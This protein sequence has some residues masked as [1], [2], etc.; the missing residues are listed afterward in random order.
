MRKLV[1]LKLCVVSVAMLFFVTECH[2]AG[3]GE[4]MQNGLK[5]VGSGLK[6]VPE[7][8]GGKKSK[9]NF[10]A[11]ARKYARYLALGTCNLLQA[12]SDMQEAVGNKELAEQIRLQAKDLKQKAAKGKATKKDYKKAF[13]TIDESSVDREQ[14]NKV[15]AKKGRI[16]LT[17]SFIHVGLGTACDARAGDLGVDL[18]KNASLKGMLR[19]GDVYWDLVQLSA[20]TIPKKIK[21]ATAWSIELRQYMKDNDIKIPTEQEQKAEAE[22]QGASQEEIDEIFA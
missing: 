2:A 12:L 1:F 22:K 13:K 8:F 14:L 9:R 4:S 17:K 11:A 21:K 5:T 20:T 19:K 3:F 15:P 6:A 7:L 10:R 18:I 16:Y